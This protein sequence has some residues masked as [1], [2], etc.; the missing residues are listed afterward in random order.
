MAKLNLAVAGDDSAV[1]VDIFR[2]GKAIASGL[3]LALPGD[4]KE[5]L[6][7]RAFSQARDVV[8]AIRKGNCTGCLHKPAVAGYDD[9]CESCWT[10]RALCS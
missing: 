8:R 9:L 2:D 7:K 5:T 4:T 6:F 1:E 10:D 3:A